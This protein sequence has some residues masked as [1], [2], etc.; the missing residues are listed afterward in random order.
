VGPAVVDGFHP[1][2]E[3]G[4]QLDQ[5][6]DLSAGADLD[7]EL[8][9]HGA[10]QSLDLAPTGRLTRFGVDQPDA[11]AGAG[12]QQLLVDECRAVVDVDRGRDAAGGQRTAQ[13]GR[14]LHGV[15]A[16]GPAVADQQPGVVIEE[17]EQDRLAPGDGRSVQRVP[18]PQQVR[19]VGLEPAEHPRR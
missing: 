4:V 15:F 6:G 10:K 11:Q 8:V 7:Q 14:E 3:P 19:R 9:A 5:V 13:R 1:G 12:A 16:V 17:G 2:G 18:G